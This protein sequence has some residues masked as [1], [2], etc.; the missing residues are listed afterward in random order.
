MTSD[1]LETVVSVLGPEKGLKLIKETRGAAVRIVRKPGENV[2]V[3]EYPPGRFSGGETPTDAR[4]ASSADN[5][6]AAS[7]SP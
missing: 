5:Q 2:Q 7:L 6:A 4:L 3:I 1:A